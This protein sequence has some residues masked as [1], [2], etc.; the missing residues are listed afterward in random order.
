MKR[1]AVPVMMRDVTLEAV[2]PESGLKI[3]VGTGNVRS[4]PPLELSD[5]RPHL[6]VCA[7]NAATDTS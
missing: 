2:G 4:R 6:N 1:K 5:M 7:D 3:I